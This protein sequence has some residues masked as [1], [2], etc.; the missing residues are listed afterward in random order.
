MAE[1]AAADEEAGPEAAAVAEVTRTAPDPRSGP[2]P[3]RYGANAAA[4]PEADANGADAE[5]EAG[6]PEVLVDVLVEE[7]VKPK[8]SAA[9]GRG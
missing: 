8:G 7:H 9:R 3:Q 5:A 6:H 4:A 2:T 1:D